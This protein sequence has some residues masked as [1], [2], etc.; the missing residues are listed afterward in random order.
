MYYDTLEWIYLASLDARLV[1]CEPDHRKLFLFGC[2]KPCFGWRIGQAEEDHCT[3]EYGRCT[4]DQEDVLRQCQKMHRAKHSF[5]DSRNFQVARLPSI[6]PIAYDRMPPK[7]PANV[8]YQNAVLNGCSSLRYH[9]GLSSII[10][11]STAASETPRKNRTVARPAKLWQTDMRQRVMPQRTRQTPM[12]L[13]TGT[14]VMSHT[15]GISIAR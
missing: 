10:Q 15:L 9:I 1:V 14:L 12:Y 2:K 11:G 8:L 4:I 13:P 6:P 5:W 7:T 3:T